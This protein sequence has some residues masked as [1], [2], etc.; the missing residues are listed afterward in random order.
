MSSNRSYWRR[1]LGAVVLLT[2]GMLL[3]GYGPGVTLANHQTTCNREGTSCW[4]ALHGSGNSNGNSP[5]SANPFTDILKKLEE[6]KTLLTNQP[7]T[8]LS[9]ATQNW[10]KNLPS[11]SR[12]TVLTAFGGAAVRDNNTGLV[13]EQ[14]PAID[15]RPWGH[16]NS[17]C[18][19]KTVGGTTGW[20]LPSLAEL[21]SVRDPSLPPPYVPASVFSGVQVDLYWSATAVADNPTDAWFVGFIAGVLGPNPKVN[22]RLAWCVRG[23]MNEH[24]Y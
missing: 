17:D 14:A 20:R 15:S 10:D 24:A 3:A 9:G 4:P 18:V 21:N 7:A 6:L 13:W 8:D 2:G 11:A 5:A 22:T 1:K 16:A 12:F 19:N 23:G